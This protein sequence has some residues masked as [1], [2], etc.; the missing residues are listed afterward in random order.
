MSTSP[1]P[2][3]MS[4][5][6][7]REIPRWADRYARHRVLTVLFFLLLGGVA[8]ALIAGLSLLAGYAWRA[9]QRLLAIVLAIAD[10]AFCAWWVRLWLSRRRQLALVA[11]ANAV[12]YRTEGEATPVAPSM[13]PTTLDRTVAWVFGA[14]VCAHVLSGFLTGPEFVLRY[15]QPLSAAYVVPFLVYLGYRQRKFSTPVMFL[16]PALYALHAILVLAGVPPFAGMNPALNMVLPVFGYG[17]L[18]VLVAHLYSRYALRKLRRLAATPED[19]TH[20]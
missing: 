13:Q 18:A 3:P 1:Q 9:D 20:A 14:S 7:A 5:D 16:W 8:Y 19:S 4:D 2:K 17:L 10:L 15:Q 6:G 12:L 11:R